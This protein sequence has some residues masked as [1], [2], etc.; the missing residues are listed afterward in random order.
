MTTKTICRGDMVGHFDEAFYRSKRAALLSSLLL[1]GISVLGVR[2][3]EGPVFYVFK[4][5]SVSHG[6]VV[7]IGI[8]TTVY[9]NVSYLLHY[10]T[11]VP[12]WMRNPDEGLQKIDDF[13][14]TLRGMQTQNLQEQEVMFRFKSDAVD[15]MNLIVALGRERTPP[16]LI[17]N[18]EAG[19]TSRL[20]RKHAGIH[21]DL[22]NGLSAVIRKAIQGVNP[23]GKLNWSELADEIIKIVS[24]NVSAR[25]PDAFESAMS[26]RSAQLSKAVD[27]S[28]AAFERADQSEIAR[29]AHLVELNKRFAEVERQLKRWKNAMNLRLRIQYLWLP[30]VLFAGALLFTCANLYFGFFLPSPKTVW[31]LS[32]GF[33]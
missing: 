19:L 31:L 3:G 15:A 25:F 12:R 9:L 30:M 17:N 4:L 26:D 7:M 10:L 11:E 5:H 18:I 33:G 22:F 14:E 27:N 1:I 13:I 24:E 32:A 2:V 21:V 6:I 23:E 8:V 20:L 28:K 16:D 29:T